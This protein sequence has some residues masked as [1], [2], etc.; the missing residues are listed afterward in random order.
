MSKKWLWLIIALIAAGFSGMVVVARH[1]QPKQAEAIAAPAPAP[2]TFLE[3]KE[4]GL[5]TT[6]E[7]RIADEIAKMQEE[8]KEYEKQRQV[9]LAREKAEKARKWGSIRL[10]DQWVVEHDR[11][12]KQASQ[13]RSYTPV[14]PPMN[15]ARINARAL[16]LMER[17]QIR[18]WRYQH[19]LPT[20][21][22]TW[23]EKVI[24][25]ADG[26]PW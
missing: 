9:R 19:G 7:Q 20:Q 18:K 16:Q 1:S 22:P 8:N 12:S 23:W 21:N 3:R 26:D 10:H 15:E 14:V 6:E 5:L 24:G 17:D 2:L 13:Y 11:L 25:Y 4:R